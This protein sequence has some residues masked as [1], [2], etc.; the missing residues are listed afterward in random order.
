MQSEAAWND[1]SGSAPSEARVRMLVKMYRLAYALYSP[2]MG[3]PRRIN[4]KELLLRTAAGEVRVIGY[5]LES[6][7]RQPAYLNMHGGGFVMGKPEAD[8]RDMLGLA[9]RLG[10]KV[11]NIDYS[12]SPEAKF[13]KALNEC[14]EVARNI[15]SN[16][17]S[18]GVDPER[19]AIGGDSAG[20]NLGAGM[21]IM[22]AE[23]VELGFKC[24]VMRC[25]STDHCTDPLERP[26]PPKSLSPRMVRVFG[27]ALLRPGDGRNPLASPI[28][29][30][31]EL[32]RRFPP[33]LVITAELDSV[34]PEGKLFGER[35]SEAGVDVD[36]E[37]FA[38]CSHGFMK[39]RS[40]KSEQA[41]NLVADYLARHLVGGD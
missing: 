1:E 6:G 21:C 32:L 10:I 37:E 3:R 8:E 23:R 27:A 7:A 17:D 20:G 38:G 12:L 14:F 5:G 31:P 9:S 2:F 33:T 19:I 36:Y 15:R 39:F 40:K 30:P 34:T 4:G 26:R 16:A 28:L 24:L 13:P 11:F 41:W 18:F 22:D 25:A 29:A 35:L